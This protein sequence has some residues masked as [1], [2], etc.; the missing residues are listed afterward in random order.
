MSALA[1]VSPH[2]QDEHISP[3]MRQYLEIKQRYDAYLL[4]YRMGDFYELFFGDAVRAA[5]IL[6]IALTKRGTYQD[7]PIPMCGVPFHAAEA[8]LE[9]LINA[10]EKVAICEQLETPDQ[11]KQRGYKSV[12]HRDVVRIVTA[13]TL[14][15]ESLLTPAK[16]NYLASIA[17]QQGALS[18]AW[19][20]ISTGEFATMQVTDSALATTIA[21]LN[22]SEIVLDEGLLRDESIANALKEYRERLSLLPEHSTDA[23]HAKR[24]LLEY[25]QTSTLDAWG[26]MTLSDVAACGMLCDYIRHTQKD[27]TPRLDPPR[28]YAATHLMQL[29]AATQRNLELTHTLS[30]ERKG[31]VLS[32]LD[33]T[34]TSGGARLLAARVT[35]PLADAGMITARLD[36]VEWCSERSERPTILAMLR[37]CPD[38]ERALGRLH[39]GR[40]GPRDMLALVNGM[41]IATQ[42]YGLCLHMQVDFLPAEME[43]VI[44]ALGDYSPLTEELNRALREDAPMLA[45]DGG[46]VRSGYHPALDELR[47]LRDESTR[48]IA[49]ME[50]RYSKKSSIPTL[51]IKH[52]NVL[53]YFVEITRRH[54]AN[55]PPEFIHR[56]TMKDALRYTTVELGE[57]EQKILRAAD[58]ALK[59]ELEIYDALMQRITE[60]SSRIVATARA[61]ALLDV[62]MSLAELAVTRGYC[63]PVVDASTR[64][65]ITGGRHP[66]VEHFMGR[67]ASTPFISNDCRLEEDERLWLLTGP[68]MAGKSTFLRQNA[69]IALMAQMGSYVPASSAHIG[70]VDKLFSRVGAADDLAKGHSTFMVE[71]VETAAI[72]NQATPRSLVILD[73]IGRGT[74]TYDGLSIA[75]AVV[76]YLH[77]T[78]RCRGLF[79]THYHELTHLAETLPSLACYTMRVKEWKGDVMF[80]HEVMRGT[81]DRSYGIHVAKLAGLPTAVL[82]RART[83][84][85]KLEAEQPSPVR[86]LTAEALP[87]FSINPKSTFDTPD[88]FPALPHPFVEALDSLDIDSLTPRAALE[89][90]YEWKGK[91]H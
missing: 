86:A 1:A 2:T 67:E 3:S 54:E 21:R 16:A 83:L 80:L 15:E 72:L 14:T 61:L 22:P 91:K 63:R 43:Q 59:L 66:V 90:L 27:A 57:M 78:I 76:E 51:K 64:F 39:V 71:M 47:A 82:Q 17:R 34:V 36:A 31:S 46:F 70:V 89:W 26:D 74:A 23:R 56:Q 53:G 84:L 35:Q 45:R 33:T 49:G 41:T 77:H 50:T 4:F 18:F 12:I 75:W 8:Y 37:Q 73:E 6:D 24:H 42:L 87:L 29:D 48:V 68:N 19:V 44:H 28:T 10:G 79:A 88:T 85:H 7:Q 58:K 60:H 38:M 52:N 5:T 30:G 9:R 11:A 32:V 25:Y 69:L 20:D 62:S 81:A 55:V 13:G 40:G 65:Y